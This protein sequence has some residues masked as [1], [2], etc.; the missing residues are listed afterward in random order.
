MSSRR[1][2]QRAATERP[3]GVIAVVPAWTPLFA[4]SYG[5]TITHEAVWMT[6]RVGGRA[7]SPAGGWASLSV[8]EPSYDESKTATDLWTVR[9]GRS[10]VPRKLTNTK[11]DDRSVEWSPDERRI[12]FSARRKDDSASQIYVGEGISAMSMVSV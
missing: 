1:K 12:A 9:T 11:S 7:V 8:T 6:K 5:H 2:R 4:Q 3:N 10:A